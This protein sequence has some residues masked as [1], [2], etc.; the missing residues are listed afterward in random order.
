MLGLV[1]KLLHR[2]GNADAG[3]ERP[4]VGE[5]DGGLGEL[6]DVWSI[7]DHAAAHYGPR[8]AVVDGGADATLYTYA[9]LHRRCR[10]LAVHS[11]GRWGANMRRLA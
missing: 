8:I 5:A 2:G 1:R 6:L 11:F 9:Q 3:G 7:L 4:D 10:Q